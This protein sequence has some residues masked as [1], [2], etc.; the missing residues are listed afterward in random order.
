L[1]KVLQ[2]QGVNVIVSV[3][4]PFASTRSKVDDIC[5]PYWIYIKGGLQGKDMPYEPPEQPDVTIDPTE[6]SLMQ[7]LEKIIAE[8]GDL[9]I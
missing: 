2:A 6:E 7:S 3:I 9:Q 8:V 4:A 5:Q 1:A